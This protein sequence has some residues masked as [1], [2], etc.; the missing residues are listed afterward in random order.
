MN[1]IERLVA[2]E[3]IKQLKARYFRG[4][5][6]KDWD[7]FRSVFVEDVE[8]DTSEAFTPL[9]CAGRAI[10]PT[11]PARAPDPALK[12][13]GIDAFMKAQHRHL[14]GMSTVHHGHMPEIE[15]LS[16]TE[17]T[18]IWAMEDK[19]RW[20]EGAGPMRLMH[21]YGHYREKYR[22]VDGKWRIAS[23]KLTRLR[24]DTDELR[25]ATGER[26]R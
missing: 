16:D 8:T 2:I 19:L 12:I 13:A 9:D 6:T 17:A 15:I 22:K 25:S 7:L 11:R 3:E 5:D 21:G 10:E 26:E 24:V 18:G 1:D 20:P 4:M 23:L 14:D